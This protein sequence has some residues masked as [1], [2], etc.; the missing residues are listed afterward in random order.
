MRREIEQPFLRQDAEGFPQRDA[1]DA[2][3]Q[4]QFRFDQARA[5]GEAAGEDILP[6]PIGDALRQAFGPRE[7]LG[8]END[9]CSLDC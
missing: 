6:Q 7:G 4:D 3:A 2:G 8:G 9:G 5:R 1:T